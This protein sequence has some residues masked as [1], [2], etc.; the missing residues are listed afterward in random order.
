MLQFPHM[1]LYKRKA[2]KYYYA[3][4]YIKRLGKSVCFSTGKTDEAEAREVELAFKNAQERNMAQDKIHAIVDALYGAG[5]AGEREKG[6]SLSQAYERYVAALEA[7]GK[8]QVGR[9]L[10]YKKTVLDRLIDWM[11]E[12]NPAAT[13]LNDVTRAIA[14]R[15]AGDFHA[16]EDLSDKTKRETIATLGRV[17]NV[18]MGTDDTIKENPWRFFLRSVKN[19]RIGRAF[20]LEQ[21]KRLFSVTLGTE[22]HT[23]SLIARFTGL[24]FGDIANLKWSDID[25]ESRAIRIKPSKTQKHGIAVVLPMTERLY[26]TLEVKRRSTKGEA[27]LPEINSIYPKTNRMSCGSF[28]DI[29]KEARIDPKLYTFHSWRH[30]FRTR[31]SE[32]GVSDDIAK[33]LGG[34]TQDTTAM[35]YDH[36][37]RI[38]AMRDAVEKTVIGKSR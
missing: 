11:R 28:S 1:A 17:W 38:E 5:E 2:S 15:F 23:A 34:W 7:V 31:L 27:V 33:R 32:A 6:V 8:A 4:V 36:A 37:E 18:L 19:Q 16:R 35:R 9:N 26:K 29:L 24:R 12:K 3:Q 20:T 22:W 25:W 21:E 30:T 13:R 10:R 14:G